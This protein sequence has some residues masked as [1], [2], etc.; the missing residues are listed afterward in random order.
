[1]RFIFI[2]FLINNTSMLRNFVVDFF[3]LLGK[4]L[5]KKYNALREL[6]NKLTFS[7]ELHSICCMTRS[8][9]SRR[10]QPA[11]LSLFHAQV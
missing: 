6:I 1:M 2:Y 7:V 5:N 9:I 11:C 10:P 8:Y 4:K 3:S